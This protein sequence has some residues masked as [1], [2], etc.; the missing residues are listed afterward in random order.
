MSK[1]FN[2][3]SLEEA[4]QLIRKAIRGRARQEVVSIFQAYN[5]VLAED[6]ASDV[7]LPSVSIS[8]FDGYAVRAE[9]TSQASIN[10]PI[11]LRV[12]GKIYLDEEYKGEVNV[13]EAVYISTGCKLP[14]GANAVIPVELAKTKGEFIEVR[15]SIR[16]YENVIPAGMDVK[17]REVIFKVGHI[18]R[19]QDIK[20]L[21][22]IKKWKVKV[23][24]K[25]VVA[26]ASVG[27]E[28]TD[29]IE[30]VGFKKFNSHG[31]MISILVEEAGGVPLDLGIAPD[32]VNAIKRLLRKGLKKADIVVTIG[33]ASVGERDYVWEVINLLGTPKVMVRGIKVQPGRVTS[34]SVVVDKPI[35]MLP[36]HV[37][38]TLVGFYSMLLPLIRLLR[39]LPSTLPLMTLKAK[40]SQKMMFKRYASFERIRF[41][42]ATKVNDN[43]VAKPIEGD[44][45]L[46]SVLVKA[47]GF[48]VIPEGKEVVER[49]EEVNVYFLKGL[50]P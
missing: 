44:S 16:P 8:H 10:N 17:R 2:Y 38:S 22:D 13:S 21:V 20:F 7:D 5:R 47:N 27:S 19:S 31:L 1:K 3:L 26:I 15:H 14:A 34:L 36:G 23:F 37:Q 4:H 35:V 48:I 33:G 25:P 46:T 32:D 29:R 28:L 24:K 41:V 6:I 42:R 45:P 11:L 49:G 12:V 18:L 40:M 43:Y 30:D 50:F 9:D 39:G